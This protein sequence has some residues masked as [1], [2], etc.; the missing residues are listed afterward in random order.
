MSR[1]RR[2]WAG[3]SEAF[4]NT[5]PLLQHPGRK[6]G[7]AGQGAPPAPTVPANASLSQDV[8]SIRTG[9]SVSGQDEAA[10][11]RAGSVSPSPGEAPG[12]S[13][14][15]R[16][17]GARRRS[18]CSGS[19]SPKDPAQVS[20]ASGGS[21]AQ[22][23]CWPRSPSLPPTG[24]GQPLCPGPWGP[25]LRNACGGHCPDP[26]VPA[27]IQALRLLLRQRGCDRRGCDP[28]TRSAGSAEGH[29]PA[30]SMPTVG[31]PLYP[32]GWRGEAGG[33]GG[34]LLIDAGIGG[35]PDPP[36]SLQ[37]PMA[38]TPKQGGP[39]CIGWWRLSRGFE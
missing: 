5:G 23:V 30:A 38:G 24:Q 10:G 26:R 1:P 17:L 39:L 28:L 27:S 11:M 37:G 31:H 34:A 4:R 9:Q 36:P 8:R 18:L 20:G 3:R 2:P 21:Q 15:G 16:S 19:G 6:E 25:A 32:R 13:G 7:L 35:P 22:G 14:G 33:S 12:Y 29:L